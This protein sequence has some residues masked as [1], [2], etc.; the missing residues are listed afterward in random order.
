MLTDC[1]STHRCASKTIAIAAHVTPSLW[2]KNCFFCFYSKCF[3]CACKSAAAQRAS[4]SHL[5]SAGSSAVETTLTP[6]AL[7]C[8]SFRPPLAALLQ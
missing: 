7:P 8:A 3:M 5:R 6:C 4:S 1:E 2:S